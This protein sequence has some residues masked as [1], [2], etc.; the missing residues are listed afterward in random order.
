MPLVAEKRAGR[1]STRRRRRNVVVPAE[2][3]VDEAAPV[4]SLTVIGI[5]RNVDRRHG[6]AVL[7]VVVAP[8]AAIRRPGRWR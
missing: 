6:H 5:T 4:V 8:S 7:V 1:R 2:P 3:A